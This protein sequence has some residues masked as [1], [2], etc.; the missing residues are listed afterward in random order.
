MILFWR[1][2][3]D[4]INRA[5]RRLNPH[6]SA[7]L[8]MLLIMV[9]SVF[10]VS[11]VSGADEKLGNVDNSGS[12]AIQQIGVKNPSTDLWRA[13]RQRNAIEP[14]GLSSLAQAENLGT[15]AGVLINVKG[16]VWR[17]F[18]RNWLLPYGGYFLIGALG[19]LL[20]LYLLVKNVKIPNG[21]S[22]KTVS[23]LSTMQRVSHWFMVFLIGFMGLT[24]L[25]LL[26]GRLVAIPI[27]GLEGFAFIASAS[28]EGH[29]LFGPLVIIS[30][31][32]ML[33]Y[34]IRHNWPA[35]G[36]IKWLFSLGGLL[37]KK[38]LKIGFF[39]A[40]E[41][42]LFW[43]TIWLGVVLSITGLLLLFP[44]YIQTEAYTQ[45]AIIIH[46]IAALLL[47]AIA[48]AHIW[49]VVTIEGTMDAMKDGNV[50]ENWAKSHHS[51][52]YEETIG[53]KVLEADIHEV[54]TSSPESKKEG[55]YQ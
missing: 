52:W 36:D 17:E 25:L 44:Y 48:F 21:R 49:M 9:F 29:N 20:L 18:R 4:A 34:F 19:F 14:Q 5:P 50:D 31:L 6:S 33:F 8:L 1:E 16:Q 2:Y 47:I 41:K 43:F 11:S 53:T 24:G 54:E 13:V 46:A 27:L 55:V 28:K 45:L 40:G 12:T 10:S 32:L 3:M 51:R 15:G 23:R 39:N 26:F 30:L 38:H 37:S 35:K 42:L 7:L 22:G